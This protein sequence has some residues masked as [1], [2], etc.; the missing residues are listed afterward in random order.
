M[1]S[2]GA[3]PGG[4]PIGALGLALA[5]FWGCKEAPTPTGPARV[6]ADTMPPS[7]FYSP[8]RDT[9]VDSIGV[10]NI[11]VRAHAPLLIDSVALLVTG[12][13]IVFPAVHPADTVFVGSFPVPLGS[14]RHK[15]FSF[16]VRADDILGRE[17]TTPSVKVTPR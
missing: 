2:R 14:L 17:G 8:S 5:L 10:L 13:S 6:G 9:V 15:P 11:V 7:V 4:L 16:A 3:F 1:V 12:A